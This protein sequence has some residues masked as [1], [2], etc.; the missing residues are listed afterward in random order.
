MR[1]FHL[2]PNMNYG[3]LQE[4]VR[5]L[6]LCQRQSGHSVTIGCWTNESNNPE[7]EHNLDH[8][9][10]RIIY[11]RRAP[12]GEMAEWDPKSLFHAL[13]GH[14]RAGKPD[15]L[16]VHNPFNYYLYGAVAA[17]V[18]GGTRIVNTVHATGMFDSKGFGSRSR[19]KF[20]AAAMLSNALV[21]VCQEVE[22]L[23][24]RKYLFPS[25]KMAVVENG[26]DLARFLAVPAR[27]SR[28]E[29]VF[30]AVGRMSREKNQRLLIEA[31]A[32]ARR[33]HSNIRLRLLGGGP[34]EPGLKEL[35]HTIGLDDSVEFCGFSNEVPR[36]LGGIDVFAL[37]S[38]TEGLPLSLLEAIASGLPV[39]ATEVGG[40]PRIVRN[41]DSGWL[42]PP[43][44]AG[45]LQGAMEA[46]IT[47]P[48]L[49][50]RGER[51]RRLVSE[52][53]SAERMT[54]DYE[55]LYQRLLQ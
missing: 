46:A 7:T 41:T 24:R 19:A 3:G 32:L 27:A 37:P 48:D 4:V 44:N 16:H 53:Y 30:G 14:L 54:H 36:F 11:L 34:H 50:D 6:A 42:C 55:Q 31:F 43:Q 52:Q 21:S 51:A 25:N 35:V 18:V 2:V 28:N 5:G 9:G 23:V 40:V 12:D 29:I 13:K 20:W 33:N 15:I 45:A 39:V 8:A 49:R 22:T 1:I 38:N 10:V 26:I 47:C 17:R